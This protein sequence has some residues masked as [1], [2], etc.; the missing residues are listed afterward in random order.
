MGGS[1]YLIM[2]CFDYVKMIL[3]LIVKYLLLCRL[4]IVVRIGFVRGLR[5]NEQ[6]TDRTTIQ[7]GVYTIVVDGQRGFNQ[8]AWQHN[9]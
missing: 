9:L 6:S 3:Y 7:G 1:V 2:A 8:H 4:Y 5:Y